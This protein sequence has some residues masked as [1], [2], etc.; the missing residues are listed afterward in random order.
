MLFLQDSSGGSP[1]W[2][3]HY[4]NNQNGVQNDNN[5]MFQNQIM[6]IKIEFLLYSTLFIDFVES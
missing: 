5:S 2:T 4:H 6:L 3:S 1:K